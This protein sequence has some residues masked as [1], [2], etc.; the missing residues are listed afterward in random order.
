[1]RAKR[2]VVYDVKYKEL[3]EIMMDLGIKPFKNTKYYDEVV[4]NADIIVFYNVRDAHPIVQTFC[5]EK[6]LTEPEKYLID[7]KTAPMSFR[8]RV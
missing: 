8:N 1:M 2:V 5:L 7:F 3:F 6:A 4:R